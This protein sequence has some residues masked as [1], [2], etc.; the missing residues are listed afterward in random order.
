MA[1]QDLCAHSTQYCISTSY[2]P[3]E[4]IDVIF[5]Q[6]KL[7]NSREAKRALLSCLWVSKYFRDIASHY[8]FRSIRVNSNLNSS[9]HD[10]ERLLEI[11]APSSSQAKWMSILPY[12]YQFSLSVSYYHR[13]LLMDMD[14]LFSCLRRLS[15]ALSEDP[16]RTRR[17]T[18]L[19]LRFNLNSLR[20]DGL[21]F[22]TELQGPVRSLLKMPHLESVEISGADFLSP[23]I[24]HDTHFSE[25]D[26]SECSPRHLHDSDAVGNFRLRSLVTDTT[27]P[28]K[29]KTPDMQ[30]L[31]GRLDHL[32]ILFKNDSE[33][34]FRKAGDILRFAPASK[35]LTL[36]FLVLYCRS[37][38][39]HTHMT[40][41]D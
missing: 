1:S 41:I 38:L 3:P 14:L 10:L 13:Q 5:Y 33:H 20:R 37:H 8:I 34:T 16:T 23:D 39:L 40:N 27:F 11:L 12:I 4:I 15:A 30:R 7:D 21:D 19:V 35:T 2:L 32:E 18:T 28:P 22:T 36:V 29:V 31:L 17:L 9:P 6:L 25:L 24:L 26:I